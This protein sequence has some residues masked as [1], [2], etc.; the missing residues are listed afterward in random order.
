MDNKFSPC[1]IDANGFCTRHAVVHDN[2]NL[3]PL[4]L[5][6]TEKGEKVRVAYDTIHAA[7]IAAFKA[8]GSVVQPVKKKCGQCQQ[9]KKLNELKHLPTRHPIQTKL[10]GGCKSCGQGRTM[11]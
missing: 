7:D 2:V 4:F 9:R 10:G 11:K 6:A 5:D 3:L 8:A 1:P